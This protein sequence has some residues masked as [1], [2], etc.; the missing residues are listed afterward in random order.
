MPFR[1]DG[2]EPSAYAYSAIRA[3]GPAYPDRMRR[4]IVVLGLV[5]VG[6]AVYRHRELD[7]R[8]QELAIGRYAGERT[9]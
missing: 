4:L 5:A 2:F 9:A 7:K 3:D 6:V 8:E 1:A